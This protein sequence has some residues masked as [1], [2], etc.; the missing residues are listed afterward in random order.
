MKGFKLIWR[1][2]RPKDKNSDEVSGR[3]D[4]DSS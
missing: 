2:K 3:G 4:E 1:T